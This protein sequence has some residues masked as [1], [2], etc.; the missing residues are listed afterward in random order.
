MYFCLPYQNPCWP[1][2]VPLGSCSHIQKVLPLP[3]DLL[4]VHFWKC[5]RVNFKHNKVKL[6]SFPWKIYPIWLFYFGT[7]I[8]LS[9][10][11]TGYTAMSLI[12]AFYVP[13]VLQS[14]SSIGQ[15]WYPWTKAHG[16]VELCSSKILHCSQNT[17]VPLLIFEEGI[18]LYRVPLKMSFTPYEQWQRTWCE[19]IRAHVDVPSLL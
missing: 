13:A 11:T 17:K 2:G 19:A 14:L 3:R 15:S 16:L 7:K 1:S 10:L 6:L 4:K 8:A 9:R 5:F 18:R 12:S